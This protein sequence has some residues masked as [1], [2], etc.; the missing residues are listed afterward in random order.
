[1]VTYSR[2]AQTPY[3]LEEGIIAPILN[4]HM[5]ESFLGVCGQLIISLAINQPNNC[6]ATKPNQASKDGGGTKENK[7]K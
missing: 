2:I 4:N 3:N 7:R 5:K 6:T 1:M